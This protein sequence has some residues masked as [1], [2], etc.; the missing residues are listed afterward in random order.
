MENIQPRIVYSQLKTEKCQHVGENFK[1]K[2]WLINND[3][4][5]LECS[6]QFVLQNT[7]QW[8][9]LLKIPYKRKG[10]WMVHKLYITYFPVES[11]N[12]KSR[13]RFLFV[14]SPYFFLA[15]SYLN[16]WFFMPPPSSVHLL[17]SF[18]YVTDWN[19]RLFFF[20]FS[21]YLVIFYM[22]WNTYKEILQDTIKISHYI[23]S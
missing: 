17:S 10:G 1:T 8:L 11:S 13:I 16:F 22:V 9:I 20:F 7:C 21:N 5:K 12:S 14:P 23:M 2:K 6:Y 4:S 19:K 3:N 15:A 18:S